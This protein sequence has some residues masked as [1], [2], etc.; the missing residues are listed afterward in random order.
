MGEAKRV[1]ALGLARATWFACVLWTLSGC[2]LDPLGVATESVVDPRC[3]PGLPT[4]V[5]T[6]GPDTLTGSNA[7]ECI[8]GLGGDDVLYGNGGADVIIGG[9]G[10][11]TLV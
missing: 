10:A 1:A 7:A 6:S 9:D 5:G 4:L 11:D 8:L 3:P 2:S